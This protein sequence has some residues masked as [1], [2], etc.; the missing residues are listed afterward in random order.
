MIEGYV[1]IIKSEQKS[2]IVTAFYSAYFSRIEKLSSSDLER[3]LAE[4]DNEPEQDMS[5]E[6]MYSVMKRLAGA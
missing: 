2:G 6:Q 1:E 5:S 3:V 4:M